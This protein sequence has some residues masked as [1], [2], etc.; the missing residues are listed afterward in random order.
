MKLLMISGDRSLLQGKQGAFYYLLQDFSAQF[1]R[2]DV[3]CPCPLGVPYFSK[4]REEQQRHLKHEEPFFQNVYVHHSMNGLAHQVKW[5]KEKGFALLSEHKHEIMTAH[6]YPP[7]YNGRGAKWLHQKTRTP[8]CL[9]IHHIVG[10]PHAAS[11]SEWIGRMLSWLYLKRDTVAAVAVRTVNHSVQATLQRWG[12]PP[13]K[14]AVVPSFYLDSAVLRPDPSIHKEYDLVFCARLVEN[15]GLLPLIEAVSTFHNVSLLVIGDGPQREVA[16]KRCKIL[17][18]R[19]RVNF[20]G[21]LPNKEEVMRQIQSARILVMNSTSEGGPRVSLEAMACG[22][23]VLSTHVGIMPDVIQEG[24]SGMFTTGK[25]DDL[26]HKLDLLIHDPKLQITLGSNA[27]GI[28][29]RFE[30]TKLIREYAEF[31]KGLASSK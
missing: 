12:V 25:K 31:L 15:K 29:Q 26:V 23:P 1:E 2:I 27:Q 22:M 14:I 3:L 21:W 28:I 4:Y 7:F 8:Y 30:K 9:E 24:W 16:E 11:W 18:I 17:G 20:I 10:H 13:G 19:D 5:I 6:E